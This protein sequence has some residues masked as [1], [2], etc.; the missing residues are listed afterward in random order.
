MAL[1]ID[2]NKPK[3]YN[4]YNKHDFGE[5]A[6]VSKT[7]ASG[8]KRMK[9]EPTGNNP[10]RPRK[11]REMAKKLTEEQVL[12]MRQMD[13][14]GIPLREICKAFPRISYNHIHQVIKRMYWKNI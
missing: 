11:D 13:K 3:D 1:L 5:N 7:K 9:F 12:K 4:D 14:D 2:R 10:G 6:P 8:R